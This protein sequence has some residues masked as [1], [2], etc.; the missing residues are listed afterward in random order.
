MASAAGLHGA[1][2][3]RKFIGCELKESY[4]RSAVRN[5]DA[6]P[7]QSE[8]YSIWQQIKRWRHGMDRLMCVRPL[9]EI[10]CRTEFSKE[11]FVRDPNVDAFEP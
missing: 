2:E 10:Y 11:V 3:W 1:A 5:L 9:M 8:R 7:G 6:T 4:W